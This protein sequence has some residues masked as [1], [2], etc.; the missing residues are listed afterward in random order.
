MRTVTRPALHIPLLSP[1]VPRPVFTGLEPP[2][3]QHPFLRFDRVITSTSSRLPS[4]LTTTSDCVPDLKYSTPPTASTDRSHDTPAEEHADTAMKKKHNRALAIGGS[5]GGL[6]AAILMA[7]LLSWWIR[8]HERDSPRCQPEF[9]SQRRQDRNQQQ[10]EQGQ[11]R[12]EGYD[13]TELGTTS[14]VNTTAEVAGTDQ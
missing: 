12:P 14:R 3:A 5:F 11:Q 6:A 7:C 10:V 8:Y 1:L 13:L 9:W 4:C 2:L